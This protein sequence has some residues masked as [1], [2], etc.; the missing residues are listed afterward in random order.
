MLKRQLVAPMNISELNSPKHNG[1]S[2]N[3]NQFINP[4]GI[5]F[6]VNKLT[7]ENRSKSQ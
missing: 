4:F 7:Q 1:I 6:A 5:I 3:K 2:N